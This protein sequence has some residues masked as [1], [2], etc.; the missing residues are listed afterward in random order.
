MV[1]FN[2]SKGLFSLSIALSTIT[3]ATVVETDLSVWAHKRNAT[4]QIAVL[5]SASNL[6]ESE[7]KKRMSASFNPEFAS[8]FR[9]QPLF[10]SQDQASLAEETRLGD[11]RICA[12]RSAQRGEKLQE[13]CADV[14]FWLKFD[15]QE[16]IRGPLLGLAE[17]LMGKGPQES[18]WQKWL[19]GQGKAISRAN[20]S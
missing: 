20:E 5:A 6:N 7:A 16:D 3:L 17:S 9:I 13:L 11:A 18:D 2:L 14:L 10:S 4:A 1:S 19:G 15:L 12:S 8:L